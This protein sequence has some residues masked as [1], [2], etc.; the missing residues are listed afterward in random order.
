MQIYLILLMFR[1]VEI[2]PTRLATLKK[3]ESPRSGYE[4]NGNIIC[5]LYDCEL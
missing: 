5:Y 3:V 2:L 4:E 1:N